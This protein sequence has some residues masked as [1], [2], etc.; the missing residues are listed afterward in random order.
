MTSEPLTWVGLPVIC[1]KCGA[2]L[3]V[4]EWPWCPHEQAPHFGEEPMESYVDENIAP[5]PVE[6]TTRGQR[7]AIMRESNLEYKDVS[8]KKRGRVYVCMGR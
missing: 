8:S 6:I 4:G 5:D 3:H 2:D 7:R 1:E